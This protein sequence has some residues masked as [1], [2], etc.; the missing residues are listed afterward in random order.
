M[1]VKSYAP[2]VCT[3]VELST[4]PGKQWLL[5]LYL[6]WDCQ[7]LSSGPDSF[8]LEVSLQISPHHVG[9]F[10]GVRKDNCFSGSE[11][12]FKCPVWRPDMILS[13][14]YSEGCLDCGK[15]RMPLK[16]PEPH[17]NIIMSSTQAFRT[18][19][20]MSQIQ[21]EEWEGTMVWCS[22]RNMELFW[23]KVQSD[24]LYCGA[25]LVSVANVVSSSFTFVVLFNSSVKK[26][27]RMRTEFNFYQIFLCFIIS[28]TN[29]KDILSVGGY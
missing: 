22:H 28:K 5:W 12:D 24:E 27:V 2:I 11:G 21:N 13:P 7:R 29:E 25:I 3:V 15:N 9:Y 8:C 10:R 23:S 1:P 4:L 14:Q 6:T 19:R 20:A 17:P 18:S 16:T 26:K